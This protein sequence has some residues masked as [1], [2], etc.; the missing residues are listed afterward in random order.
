MMK[1]NLLT[2]A[3]GGQGIASGFRDASGIAWRLALACRPDFGGS[4]EGVFNSWFLERKQQLDRS[5]ASTVVN[6]NFTT[7]RNPFKIFLRDWIIWFMTLI[8]SWRHQLELG[9]RAQGMGR[10]KF[11][12]GMAFLPGMRGGGC[13]PQVYCRPVYYLPS[14]EPQSVQFTDDVLFN[15]SRANMLLR[16]LVVINDLGEAEQA[17]LE[18]KALDLYKHSNGEVQEK[19]ALFLIQSPGPEIQEIQKSN[20]PSS[21]PQENVYRVATADDFAASDLCKSRPYPTGYDM[22]RIQKEVKGKR[23]ILVRPDRFVY[24]ACNTG[25][26]LVAACELV[27]TT[28]LGLPSTAESPKDRS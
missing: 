24:A 14:G 21:I 3:V 1:R 18:L 2:S 22:Q 16:L 20:T 10:Y 6:G 11:S 27:S 17:W 15:G 25:A 28:L 13:L 4:Y 7:A 19:S 26:E 5:L 23:F 9:P 12:Q 8:P